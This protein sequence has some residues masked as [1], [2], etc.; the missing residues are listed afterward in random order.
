MSIYIT[1]THMYIIYTYNLYILYIYYHTYIHIKS[2]NKIKSDFGKGT[3]RER[4]PE[5]CEGDHL[6]AG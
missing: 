1:Y 2:Q 3:C 5:R 4:G 6:G